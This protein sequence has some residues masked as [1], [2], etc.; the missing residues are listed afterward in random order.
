MS[1]RRQYLRWAE[2]VGLTLTFPVFVVATLAHEV[3]W[4]AYWLVT[5]P[6]GQ[7]L[8]IPFRM[9]ELWSR[10][11]AVVLWRPTPPIWTLLAGTTL[12]SA[13]WQRYHAREGS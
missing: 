12:A 5:W 8:S 3:I 4:R 7:V 2:R 10:W 1:R 13:V 6:I 11:L 9:A